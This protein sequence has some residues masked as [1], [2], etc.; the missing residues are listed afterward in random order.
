VYKY[1]VID[2]FDRNRCTFSGPLG[3]LFRYFAGSRGVVSPQGSPRGY[4]RL[5]GNVQ[6]GIAEYQPVGEEHTEHEHVQQLP[7][8]YS[9][10]NHMLQIMV[11][12]GV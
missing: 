4:Q 10:Q 12:T 11:S 3:F 7:A 9:S 1:D 2:D 5:T 8:N 6:Y